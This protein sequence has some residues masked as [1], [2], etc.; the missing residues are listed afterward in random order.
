MSDE[1]LSV[2]PHSHSRRGTDNVVS[3]HEFNAAMEHVSRAHAELVATVAAMPDAVVSR[4]LEQRRADRRLFWRNLVLA[5]T[6]VVA[7]LGG[8]ATILSWVGVR[9]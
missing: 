2:P 4:V 5:A 7:I 9:P 8:L 3:R 6:S 1:A